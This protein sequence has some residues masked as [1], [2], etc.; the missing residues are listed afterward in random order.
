[1]A[2]RWFEK[3]ES[4]AKKLLSPSAPSPSP[5]PTPSQP[6]SEPAARPTSQPTPSPP[7]STDSE[8]SPLP[9]LQERLW[10]QAYNGL[11]ASEPKLVEAYEKILSVGLHR[12]DPSSILLNPV[13]EARYNRNGI[14]YVLSRMEWDSYR[15]ILDHAKFQ[16][17]CDDPQ[18]R[19]LW[20]KGDPGKGKTMLV[21]GLIDELEEGSNCLLS[22]FFCQATQA[23][24]SNAANV[25]RGLIYLLIIQQPSLISY[26]R[27]KHDVTGEKLFQGINVWVSLVEILTDMLKDPTLKDAVLVV[28]ALDE[29]ITDRPQL[30]DFIIQSSSL[31]SSR[32]KWIISSRNWP[33]IEDKLDSAK[34][35]VTLPLE[36]N[37]DS[38]S[39]AVNM[40]IGYK[41]DRLACHKKYDKKTK[42]AV[43][44]YL[45]SNADGM[46]LWVALLKV[47]IKSLEDLDQDNLEEIIRSCGSFL[48]LR[49]GI[50]YFVHQSAKDFLLNKA[51]NQI[52]PSGAA[53]QHQAI[54]SRSLE[55]LSE[56]LERDAYKLD[57]PGF[58]ID[59]ISPPDPDPVA[60]VR[61]SCV[62]WV[63]HLDD[64]GSKAKMSD[65]ALQD[66][67]VV[68]DFIKKKYLHWLESLSP[69]RSMSEGVLAVQKL[70][71]LVRDTKTKELTELLRDARRFILSYKQA[72]EIAPLQV[73]ASALV[74][75]PTRSLVRELFGKEEPNWITL[76]LSVES[77]CNACLQTLKGH[78]S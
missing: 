45:T 40:Y 31:P 56:T 3:V 73:Y 25:L 55:A 69:L 11:K 10:N 67:G 18:S 24:L 30:L 64:S 36:L 22:Y 15:W 76:K 17:F 61:Y 52:L 63:D 38:I 59:Q 51:S 13:T 4:K 2:P 78:G 6:A 37:K 1:M 47:L 57:A 58:P 71:A 72:I 26:L 60:S 32:V 53:H 74:F 20:I 42:D 27:S 9:N 70:E 41:V 39:K 46:F 50:I 77:D 29:C 75:S 23:Q 14:A 7:T 54:F 43:E 28:D 34:Q 48:T 68:H 33:D 21:C 44:N 49:E 19:L 35:K 5:S 12:K 16:Q 65:N 66:G 62:Y 8:T